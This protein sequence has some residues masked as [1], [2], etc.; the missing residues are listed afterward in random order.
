MVEM[1]D[2]E[3]EAF[4]YFGFELNPESFVTWGVVLV[5]SLTAYAGVRAALPQLKLAWESANAVPDSEDPKA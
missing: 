4:Y 5:I 1:S 3:G 2:H